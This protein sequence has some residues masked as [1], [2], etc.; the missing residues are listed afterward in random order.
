MAVID[1]GRIVEQ[2]AVIDVFT[3]PQH[4]DHAQPD[5]RRSCRR[6][7]RQ[8]CWQRVRARLAAAGTD[9]AEAQLLRLAFAGAGVDQP[10]LS[11]AIRRYRLDFNIL[12]GQID[13]IQGQTFGSLAVPGQR[14]QRRQSDRPMAHLRERRR[15]G[16]RR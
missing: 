11:E 7:C 13:E 5:R 8:A 1:A 16:A 10:L 14:R 9:G 15:G 4:A 2:G 12:H 6:S 3:R